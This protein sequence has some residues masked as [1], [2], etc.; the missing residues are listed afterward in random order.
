M[1]KKFSIAIVM[2]KISTQKSFCSGEIRQYSKRTLELRRN[3]SKRKSAMAKL[4]IFFWQ[5]LSYDDDFPHSHSMSHRSDFV[6][7]HFSKALLHIFG[8]VI[9]CH[10]YCY[11][12]DHFLDDFRCSSI[13]FTFFWLKFVAKCFF[14]ALQ[15]LKLQS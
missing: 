12:F 8:R 6:D 5:V 1:Q 14:F 11:L 10:L 4:K 15:L 3:S 2:C 13:S 9:N 7:C